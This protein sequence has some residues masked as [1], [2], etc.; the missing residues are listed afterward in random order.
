MVHFGLTALLAVAGYTGLGV[1]C[2]GAPDPDADPSLVFGIILVACL[3][4]L[5]LSG[6][7]ATIGK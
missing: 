6:G 1:F 3:F 2:G 7:F 4:V 5:G